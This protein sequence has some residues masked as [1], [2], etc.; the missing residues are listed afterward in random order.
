MEPYFN[1]YQF[2]KLKTKTLFS[3]TKT[4]LKKKQKK[5]CCLVIFCT[6]KKKKI[7]IKYHLF[8]LMSLKRN[9][10]KENMKPT[11][12]LQELKVKTPRRSKTPEKILKKAKEVSDDEK[13]KVYLRVR[14]LINEEAPIDFEINQE[15]ITIRPHSSKNSSY[16]CVDKSFTFRKILNS[17][18]KQRH[19]Y[20]VV[21][22]PL[23][24]EFLKGNDV[25]I[26]CYGST[27][28][29][30]TFT[31]T[32]TESE[33]GI[34]YQALQKVIPTIVDDSN[35]SAVLFASYN[36]IYNERIYDLLSDKKEQLSIGINIVGDTEIKGCT[37][38]PITS[39]EDAMQVIKRG[40][41]A[42]HRGST[43]MNIDSSRS[44]SI[45]RL[46]YV[47]R[48]GYCW[49]SIVDLAGS[50]RLSIMNSARG[51]FKEAC[52]I[53]KSMLVLGKCIRCLKEQGTTKRRIP[54]P[55]RESKL[56][57][58][59]KNLFEPVKRQA[60]AAIIINI[61]PS[62][63]QLEDTIFS[64][65]FA[66]EASQC[67]IRQVLRPQD[68]NQEDPQKELIFAAKPLIDED[69]AQMRER[70]LKV[71][72]NK[73]IEEAL[74]Q[75]KMQYEHQIQKIL[76]MKQKYDDQQKAITN[77]NNEQIISKS[78]AELN[79]YNEE[80]IKQKEIQSKLLYSLEEFNSKNN[81]IENQ[82]QQIME[83]RM[84][85]EQK[86]QSLKNELNEL[87]SE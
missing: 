21:T 67:S 68:I 10:G 59:F 56:T 41:E 48:G 43:E 6:F 49:L 16:F 60:R 69:S 73:E 8:Y 64:L 55:Y 75:R 26:F 34:L 85:I 23:I 24:E 27:N 7:K 15:T 1:I 22:E 80:L 30:K 3:D 61:S 9:C 78:S 45:F 39:V 33:P 47:K 20:E 44:H 31:V 12:L 17:H 42:R 66:A 25:L 28:A 83:E 5:K 86:I 54:I 77:I 37:E 4:K 79:K 19:V 71:E 63:L 58:I 51:S 14:P 62:S 82:K 18:S 50:E 53:N 84:I 74:L 2:V 70:R 11:N 38:V 57:H 46:K 35:S 81:G 76:E 40:L 65:Q 87:Q 13:I 32:G 36:E 29:G 52:N 72:I